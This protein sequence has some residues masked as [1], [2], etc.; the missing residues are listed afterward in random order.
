MDPEFWLER[1]QHT[2]IGFHQVEI[3]AHL[4]AFWPG[5]GLP[6][7]SAIFVPLCGKSRDMLWLRASGHRVLGVE[8]SS[9][10]VRDFFSENGLSPHSNRTPGFECH[11]IDGLKLCQGD[12]FDLGPG[13]LA[14]CAGVYDRASLVAL[15][16]AMRERYAQHLQRMLPIQTEI[17]LV[18]MEYPEGEMQGPPFSVHEHEVRALY[19]NCYR[20]EGLFDMDMLAENPQLRKKGLTRLQEKVYRLKPKQRA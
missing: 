17:L 12:F 8:I 9:I 11:E 5:L 6:E 16:P 19:G 3:N 1:W 20:V 10:A 15:P 13:D 7:G 14:D 2:Q 18:T 4:Q